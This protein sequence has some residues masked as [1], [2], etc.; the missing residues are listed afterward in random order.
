MFSTNIEKTTQHNKNYRQV[1]FTDSKLQLVVMSIPPNNFIPM[2][3]HKGS[4]FIRVEAGTGVIRSSKNSKR[5][6]DGVAVIIPPGIQHEVKSTGK[7][8]LKLYIIY[9]PPE[10]K[11]NTRQKVQLL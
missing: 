4:Q 7:T 10:H 9:A 2:E 5:L 1:L 8:P 11:K 6:K 3:T